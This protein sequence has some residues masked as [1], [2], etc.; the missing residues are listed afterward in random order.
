[1][2][3][4]ALLFFLAACYIAPQFSPGQS[5]SASQ[6]VIHYHYGDNPAW[7][8]PNFDDSAWH[9]ARDGVFPSPAYQ[10]DGY[11]WVRARVPVP[12]GLTGPLAIESRTSNPFPH[13]QELWVNG[14]LVG[15]YGN[16]PPHARPLVSPQS[17]VYDIPA[18]VAP[19]GSIAQIALR[20]WNAPSDGSEDLVLRHPDPSRV[21]FTIAPASLLHALDAQAQDRAWLNYWPQLTLTLLFVMLGLAV[22][23]LGI[24]TQ[25][26]TLLLCALW[27]VALPAYIA[28]GPLINLLVG[29]PTAIGMTLFLLINAVGMCVVVEF[30]WT[31]QG[32]SDRIFRA[33]CH[34]CWIVLTAASIYLVTTTHASSLAI[35]GMYVSNWSLFAFNVIGTGASVVALAGLGK[36]RPVAAAQIL[37]SVGYLLGIAGHPIEFA[38][39]GLSFFKLAFYVC[40]LFIAVLLMRQ[41]WLAWRSGEN[42]RV[43]FAAAR[44][45]QQQLVPAEPPAIAGWRVQAA[46]LPAAEVGGDFYHLIEQP[47]A[48]IL[49]IGDVSGKG[50]KAAMTGLLTIGAASALAAECPAPAQLLT[51]LNREMVRLQK[52]GFITCLCARI[53]ADGAMTIANAGHLP[54]YRNGDEIELESGLPLGIAPDAAYTE[55]TLQLSPNDCLTFLS[56]GVV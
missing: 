32:F 37:I 15:R 11:F 4:W 25:D 54:P 7:A 41:T 39:L 6:P 1:M 18:G 14:H 38:W 44:E 5:A 8:N 52:G 40:T 42:L 21:Q 46:Y 29:T 23:A 9:S 13:V 50:L 31:V 24:R 53:A 48:T 2:R 16:F 28:A 35:A 12:A 3:K 33:A 22:L 47:G 49:L 17:L 56:D 43:E 27:L 30:T 10:S 20:T 45:V 34:F 55:S 19:P 26:R 36:N 51:R